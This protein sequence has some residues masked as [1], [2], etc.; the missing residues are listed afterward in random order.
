MRR[1]LTVSTVEFET[2][3][4]VANTNGSKESTSFFLFFPMTGEPDIDIF[5]V[6]AGI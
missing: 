4:W 6:Y 2:V 3:L 5:T 1:A